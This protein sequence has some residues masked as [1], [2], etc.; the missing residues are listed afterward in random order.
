[1]TVTP[2]RRT[3]TELRQPFL[4]GA[5]AATSWVPGSTGAALPTRAVAGLPSRVTSRSPPG[6]AAL[7]ASLH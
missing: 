2:G 5:L 4:W 3:S 1:M 6:S 7:I